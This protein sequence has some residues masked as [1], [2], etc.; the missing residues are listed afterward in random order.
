MVVRV[1]E[2]EAGVDLSI[3][4]LKATVMGKEDGRVLVLVHGP[5][6]KSEGTSGAD[7]IFNC[8]RKWYWMD[9]CLVAL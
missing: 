6:Q 3:R 8:S 2:S 9:C 5:A 1:V 4:F 7:S